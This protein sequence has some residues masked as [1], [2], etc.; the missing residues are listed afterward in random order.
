MRGITSLNW[1][2]GAFLLVAALLQPVAYNLFIGGEQRA[3]EANV[4]LIAQQQGRRQGGVAQQSGFIEFRATAAEVA[5]G[6]AALTLENPP[7]DAD[8]FLYSAKVSVAA[9]GTEDLVIRAV[10]SRTALNRAFMPIGPMVYTY[11]VNRSN[12]TWNEHGRKREPLLGV[13]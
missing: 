5:K 10:P 9:D 1:F 6:Y 13:L 11:S 8:T 12:G 3:A 4:S 2:I 7:T